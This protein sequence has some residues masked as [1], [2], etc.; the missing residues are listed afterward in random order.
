MPEMRKETIRVAGDRSLKV[1]RELDE[2]ATWMRKLLAAATEF[3]FSPDYGHLNSMFSDDP[4]GHDAVVLSWRGPSIEGGDPDRWAIK[5]HGVYCWSRSGRDWTFEP[6]PSSRDNGFLDDH[7]FSRDE[8]LAL[9]SALL[10]K[11]QAERIP[12]LRRMVQ[13]RAKRKAADDAT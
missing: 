9:V 2:E 5:Y 7:R 1:L 10:G 12:E 6:R 8:A 3:T 4:A 13:E 11:I